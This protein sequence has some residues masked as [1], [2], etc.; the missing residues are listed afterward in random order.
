MRG[1][2]IVDIHFHFF[3]FFFFLLLLLLLFFFFHWDRIRRYNENTPLNLKDT[4]PI[5]PNG[6]KKTIGINQASFFLY[7]NSSQ[8][9]NELLVCSSF[10]LL[11]F[12]LATGKDIHKAI[13]DMNIRSRDKIDQIV[14]ADRYRMMTG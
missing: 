4:I 12:G 3:F 9:F 11:S 13:H 6:G 14:I 8:N 5:D 2:T 7:A 10:L 1:W